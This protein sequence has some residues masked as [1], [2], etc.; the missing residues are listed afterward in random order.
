MREVEVKF[1]IRDPEALLSA[2]ETRRIAVG[3]PVHHDDQAYAPLGW[4]FGDDKLGVTFLRLRSTEG[5]HIFTLKRPA[6]N[7]QS[8]VEHETEVADR[9]QMHRAILAMG[10]YPTVKIVK[11]RRTATVGDIEICIDELAGV[12]SFLELERMISSSSSARSVQR[13]LAEFVADLAVEA[14]RVKETYDALVN[15]ALG[16]QTVSAGS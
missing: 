10:F 6:E 2:L 1:Q 4:R 14:E 11:T 3:D 5:R 7:V 12:G 16:G 8:C 9:G 15:A 13:E